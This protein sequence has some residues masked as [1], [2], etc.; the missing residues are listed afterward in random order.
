MHTQFYVLMAGI[1]YDL[2]FNGQ[3]MYLEYVL[4]DLFDNN[5]RRI[6]IN[7]TADNSARLFIFNKVEGQPKHY[8]FNKWNAVDSFL[9]DDHL[10]YKFKVY[11]ALTNN[12]NV[13]PDTNPA[14]W[15]YVM[16][17]PILFNREDYALYNT[18]FI[19]MYPTGL[20]FDINRMKALVNKYK[21]AGKS[22][23]IQSY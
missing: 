11:K 12:S 22:Y 9:M 8:V 1:L 15:Q 18:S 17:A 2:Q 19:V 21:L 3:I 10:V 20:S 4:N 5:L 23:T 16:A 7:N 6:Y 14:V 13:A